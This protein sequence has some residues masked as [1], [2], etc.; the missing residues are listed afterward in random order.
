MGVNKENPDIVEY[1]EKVYGCPLL[2]YQK[3]FIRKT[4]D[5][6]INNKQ[7]CCIPPRGSSR[8]NLELL[9]AIVV[10]IGGKERGLVNCHQE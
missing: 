1:V 7:L 8:L 6:L 5:S 4:Y 3:E 10:I 9:R 2:D